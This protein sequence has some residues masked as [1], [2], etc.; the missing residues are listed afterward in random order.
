MNL[1]VADLVAIG[2][3]RVAGRLSFSAVGTG[4]GLQLRYSVRQLPFGE[5]GVYLHERGDCGSADGSSAGGYLPVGGGAATAEGSRLGTLRANVAGAAR[6]SLVRED[7]SM[8]LL[9]DRSVL[10]EIAPEKGASL[11]AVACG[12]VQAR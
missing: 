2:G 6:G 1:A 7:A 5:H 8:E 12:V 4:P 9:L 10:I 3:S 11:R